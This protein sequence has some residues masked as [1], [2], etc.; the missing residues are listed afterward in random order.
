MQ[1]RLLEILQLCDH[2]NTHALIK[3]STAKQA[4]FVRGP[5]KCCY[6]LAGQIFI[7][8]KLHSTCNSC[9]LAI[10]IFD[11]PLIWVAVLVQAQGAIPS[12]DCKHIPVLRQV[13][14]APER[15]S[16]LSLLS[17]AFKATLGMLCA[18]LVNLQ[19]HAPSKRS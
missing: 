5:V 15:G 7:R 8:Q 19:L 18:C 14:D 12:A 17:Q 9:G 6:G 1:T 4:S 2:S 3:G 11:L 10:G 13:L 16:R